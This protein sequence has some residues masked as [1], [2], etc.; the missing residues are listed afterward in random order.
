MRRLLALTVL[1]SGC[2]APLSPEE[3]E[4]Q[5]VYESAIEPCKRKYPSIRE[6]EIDANGHLWA[7]VRPESHAWEGFKR[8]AQDAL[9]A[10]AEKRSYGNGRLAAKVGTVT[11]AFTPSGRLMLVPATLNGVPATLLLDT[12]ATITIIRPALAQRAGIQVPARAPRMN[13]QVA[14]GERFSVPF[15]KV[16]ALAIGDAVVEGIDIGVGDALVRGFPA[17]V[18]GILGNNY[19]SHFRMTIDRQARQVILEPPAR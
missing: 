8:C 6:V 3:A 17:S 9:R 1:V 4:R 19:L 15:V 7:Q 10:V 18:D 16:Q 5:K 13:V 12:G 11:V 2:A 14:G